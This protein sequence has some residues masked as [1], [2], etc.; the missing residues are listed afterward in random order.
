MLFFI[1]I[2]LIAI[3]F[4]LNFFLIELFFF[5]FILQLWNGKGLSFI[6]FFQFSFYEL[7]PVSWHELQVWKVNPNLFSVVSFWGFFLFFFILSL[8]IWLVRDW[9]F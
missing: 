3:C 4:S 6:F 5:N 9:V 7:I 2:L 8:N 1:F